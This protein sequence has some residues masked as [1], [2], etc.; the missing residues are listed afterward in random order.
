MVCQQGT[1]TS[2]NGKKL[3]NDDAVG[4]SRI[5]SS[6]L[7]NGRRGMTKI[8]RGMSNIIITG[9]PM[10][11][12]QDEISEAKGENARRQAVYSPMVCVIA[13]VAPNPTS[14]TP[15]NRRMRD[16]RTFLRGSPVGVRVLS[17]KKKR[18]LRVIPLPCRASAP[19]NQLRGVSRRKEQ[20][21]SKVCKEGT[22]KR[23]ARTPAQTSGS[24]TTI[25]SRKSYLWG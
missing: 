16:L 19:I 14:C 9:N 4:P 15:T 11:A 24:D 17:R 1:W 3:T 7:V 25:T 18:I 13:N 6:S 21:T 5:A 22:H 8:R 2:W 20:V 12:G 10:A 23:P